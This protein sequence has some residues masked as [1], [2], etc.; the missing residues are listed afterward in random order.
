[1][2]GLKYNESMD[3]N[4]LERE[5]EEEGYSTFFRKGVNLF[6]LFRRLVKYFYLSRRLVY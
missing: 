2:K 1:M 5:E 6:N 4:Y 3:E